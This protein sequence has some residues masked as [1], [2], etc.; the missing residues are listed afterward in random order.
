[1]KLLDPNYLELLHYTRVEKLENP[2]E[3]ENRR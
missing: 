3:D 1:M 2:Q